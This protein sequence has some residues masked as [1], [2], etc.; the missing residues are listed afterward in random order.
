MCKRARSRLGWRA[1]L[2]RAEVDE[3][4][5]AAQEFTA[6]GHM[7]RAARLCTEAAVLS[8]LLGDV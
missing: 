3:R 5:T 8:D 1:V 6:A 7:E 2:V 4:M